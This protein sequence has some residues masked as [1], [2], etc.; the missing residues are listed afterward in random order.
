MRLPN[1]DCEWFCRIGASGVSVAIDFP[2][3]T[4]WPVV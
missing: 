4:F 1:R 2:G 3:V